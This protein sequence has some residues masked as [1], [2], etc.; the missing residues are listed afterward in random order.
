MFKD[1]FPRAV[2]EKSSAPSAF[3]PTTL[4]VFDLQAGAL[5]L[6]YNRCAFH[7]DD[8]LS[9]SLLNL[10]LLWTVHR[11][12]SMLRSLWIGYC[13]TFWRL[14]SGRFRLSPIHHPVPT[15]VFRRN[16]KNCPKLSA[17]WSGSCPPPSRFFYLFLTL[18]WLIL[19][20]I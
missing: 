3:E 16:Q 14:C 10:P 7:D 9:P 6:C 1:T 4:G 19:M 11:D 18:I 13:W 2:R 5:P 12:L 15:E 17:P 20:V 8:H